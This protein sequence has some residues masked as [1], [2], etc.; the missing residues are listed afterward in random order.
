VGNEIYIKVTKDGPYMVYGD[1]KLVEQMIIADETGA[2]VRYDDG[3]TYKTNG[4]VALCRC[5]E[6]KNAPF[7]DGS[8][9]H[10][11][12]YG[13]EQASFE[14]FID[15]ADAIEGP[16]LTLLDNSDFCAYARFCDVGERVWKLTQMGEEEL[17]VKEACNCPAGR[18]VM[19]DE[20]SN[21]IENSYEPAIALLEDVSLKISGPIWVKGGIRVESA[22]GESYEVRNR[23]TLCRCG[24]SENKPFCNGAHAAIKYKAKRKDV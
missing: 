22:S 15:G 21:P 24:Q 20:A 5:G 4:A 9:K 3:E 10:A 1:P 17:S 23:Q 8:H 14:P 7:C 2:S 6:S 18:L 11:N 13:E 12:F 19:L 16:R